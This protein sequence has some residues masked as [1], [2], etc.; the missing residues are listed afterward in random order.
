MSLQS[1]GFRVRQ[2]KSKKA[3][4]TQKKAI[5]FVHF[6]SKCHRSHKSSCANLA[7]ARK[8]RNKKKTPNESVE[9]EHKQHIV[10]S[11]DAEKEK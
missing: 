9:M 2:N 3:A 11:S 4:A 5:I 8:K 1:G 6:I 7:R 10:E